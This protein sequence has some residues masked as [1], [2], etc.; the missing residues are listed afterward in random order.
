MFNLFMF[1]YLLY[2][3]II[4]PHQTQIN[5]NKEFIF[6]YFCFI[7]IFVTNFICSF[8]I[9]QKETDLN[10]SVSFEFIQF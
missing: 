5:I 4:T 9:N 2:M 6:V 7:N 1:I 8:L 3:Y 10:R